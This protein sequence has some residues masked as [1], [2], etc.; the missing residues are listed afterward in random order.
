MRRGIVS[1][2]QGSQL[3]EAAIAMP[4]VLLVLMFAVNVALASYT[5]V[6]ASNA[7]NYGARVG[8]ITREN[9]ET[10]ARAATRTALDQSGA[11]GSF[12]YSVLISERENG[13][14]LV[15]VNWSYP[16]LLSGLCRL[17]GGGCPADF[18][19]SAT[20]VWRKEGY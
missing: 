20:A 11:G 9:P 16:T 13:T 17:F 5:A 3:A 10:W 8:A 1:E 6:A 15:T 14:A 4:V 18:R 19:G 2:N 7:A 12:S